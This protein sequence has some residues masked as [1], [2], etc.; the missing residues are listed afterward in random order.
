MEGDGGLSSARRWKKI[1]DGSSGAVVRCRKVVKIVIRE[2]ARVME[3]CVF[4]RLV[5]V[6]ASVSRRHVQV[7]VSVRRR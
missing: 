4:A 6:V 1:V 7:L 2:L 3:A 5:I